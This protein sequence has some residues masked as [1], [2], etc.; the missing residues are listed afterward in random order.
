MYVCLS[1]YLSKPTK[2]T[3]STKV[4]GC[5]RFV[6]TNKHKLFIFLKR[7]FVRW[8]NKLG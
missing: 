1:I 6:Y 7:H 8:Y 3:E 4:V 5:I 2:Q